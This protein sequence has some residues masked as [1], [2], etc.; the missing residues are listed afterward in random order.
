VGS[1]S[2]HAISATGKPRRRGLRAVATGGRVGHGVVLGTGVR[3]AAPGVVAPPSGQLGDVFEGVDIQL[4][5]AVVQDGIAQC[6]GPG[7]QRQA[8]HVVV[9]VVGSFAELVDD[10]GEGL[11]GVGAGVAVE[12]VTKISRTPA[13]PCSAQARMMSSLPR[14]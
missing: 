8:G 3:V 10:Q 4:A 1:C 5:G 12:R 13:M 7:L 9:G 11:G 6:F 14:K 2:P